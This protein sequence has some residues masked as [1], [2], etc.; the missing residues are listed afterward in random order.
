MRRELAE[1]C[2]ARKANIT[3]KKPQ[4]GMEFALSDV[5]VRNFIHDPSAVIFTIHKNTKLVGAYILYLNDSLLSDSGK[6]VFARYLNAKKLAKNKC[7][8]G[9]L[10]ILDKSFARQNSLDSLTSPT[11]GVHLINRV[12]FQENITE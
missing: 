2:L 5:E 10:L 1:I 11:F 9:A 4:V 7:A 6:E 8:Y 3:L 12:I